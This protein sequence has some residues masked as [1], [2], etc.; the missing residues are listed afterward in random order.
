MGSGLALDEGFTLFED[1][2][3]FMGERTAVCVLA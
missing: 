2:R 3:V 1:E